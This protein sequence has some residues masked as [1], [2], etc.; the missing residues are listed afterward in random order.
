MFQALKL[1]SPTL[2]TNQKQALLGVKEEGVMIVH[3]IEDD[4]VHQ[5]LMSKPVILN[6][7]GE[8]L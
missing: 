3:N 6:W 5:S 4:Y 8:I 7:T 1:P 2:Q